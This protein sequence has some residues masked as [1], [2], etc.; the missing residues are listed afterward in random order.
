MFLRFATEFA[1]LTMKKY[2]YTPLSHALNV[3]CLAVFTVI[4]SSIYG[5]TVCPQVKIPSYKANNKSFASQNSQPT[6]A[7]DYASY[8]TT[9]PA[10]PSVESTSHSNN[11][12]SNRKIEF[13]TKLSNERQGVSKVVSFYDPAAKVN[14]NSG[15]SANENAT[16]ALNTVSFGSTTSS[17]RKPFEESSTQINTSTIQRVGGDPPPEPGI[18]VGDG[19]CLLAL[20]AL[21]YAL[22]KNLSTSGKLLAWIFSREK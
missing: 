6:E 15:G 9:Q 10:N 7:F 19:T 1:N 16:S 21:L 3:S 4:S 13:S 17:E 14:G 2:F 22:Y 20:F 8:E 12:K 11:S 5:Y 18:P